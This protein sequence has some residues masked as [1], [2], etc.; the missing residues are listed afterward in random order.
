MIMQKHFKDTDTDNNHEA[1]NISHKN[2]DKTIDTQ[3]DEK[4]TESKNMKII[5]VLAIFF[6]IGIIVA[7]LILTWI[8]ISKN[9]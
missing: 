3:P 2:I 5:K 6:V 4:M 9:F 1:K 8:H 7:A